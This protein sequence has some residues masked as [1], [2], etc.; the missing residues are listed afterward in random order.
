MNYNA[1]QTYWACFSSNHI[2]HHIPY[3]DLL[4][5]V[6][7]L[8]RSWA[9]DYFGMR[10]A[11]YPHSLYNA[12][13]H[14][15]PY[16]NPTWAWQIS[17]TPW[18]VQSLWWHYQYSHD[19][20]FLRRRAYPL[21]AEAITFLID[22]ALTS[23]WRSLQ[24]GQKTEQETSFFPTVAPELYGLSRR[25]K[26]NHDGLADP[27]LTK[28]LC[29]AFLAA[30]DI[31]GSPQPKLAQQALELLQSL[32]PYPTATSESGDV[33]VSVA[34]EDPEVVYNNPVPG[35]PLFPGEDPDILASVTDFE[36]ARRSQNRQLV[37]GGNDIV[38]RHL[39]AL[40][41]G[42]LDREELIRH[43]EYCELP[44]G[45]ITDMVLQSGGR[46]S[47]IAEFDFMESKGF[48]VENFATP[49]LVTEM[50]IQSHAGRIVVFPAMDGN[51]AFASLRAKGAF[52]VACLRTPEE[53]VWIEV[54]SEAGAMLQLEL[55]WHQGAV[56]IHGDVLTEMGSG[57]CSLQT[58]AG[59]SYRFT[60]LGS[61]AA[62]SER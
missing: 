35:M 53:V 30:H 49:V 20:D 22:Y 56:M 27:T 15:N 42:Q 52:L 19:I 38:F 33:Y 26:F 1:P 62:R 13:M 6:G 12:A 59:E 14:T 9:H 36:V 46:Y 2:D 32:V 31:V 24:S 41:A 58:V 10:G 37:E 48:W 7:V 4:E 23:P 16:P 55:P 25:L 18:A 5:S 28:F 54:F 29:R 57:T 50:L 17:E 40:R 47:D 43:L 21:I 8:V 34:A 51:A 3:V 39:Q 44:N 61:G 60:P 11:A 45:T